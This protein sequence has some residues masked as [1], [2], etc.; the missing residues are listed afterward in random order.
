RADDGSAAW[1]GLNYLPKA[2]RFQLSPLG[3]GLYD[4]SCGIALFLA[5]LWS[6][7]KDH[8]F[9]D[10][11][12]EALLPL[13][14]DL[15]SLDPQNRQRFAKLIGADMELGS[16]LY[17]LVR[18]SQLLE[19]PTL[20]E[21]AKQAACL[22]T[23]EKSKNTQELDMISELAG[24]ILGLLAL[25][26]ASGDITYLEQAITYGYYILSYEIPSD[27][28]L[29]IWATTGKKPWISFAHGTDRIAYALLKLYE[30]TLDIN[31]L[32]GVKEMIAYERSH[33]F[34]GNG[35]AYLSSFPV[36]DTDEIRQ[37]I[38]KTLNTTQQ[39]SF[40]RVDRLSCGNFGIIDILLEASY[41]LSRPSLLA[42]A[43]QRAAWVV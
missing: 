38:E 22:M 34:S 6:V 19:E 3:Y 8:Q 27:V 25:Q 23:L 24:V 32:V 37:E 28:G 10:F 16:I 30:T 13:R 20:L 26:I 9:R 35:L 18:I 2:E 36:L 31:F 17:A 33:G 39:I 14:Q 11:A 7:T 29:K 43:Q 42:T 5:S 21:N 4:G 1:I 40:D 15:Q 41:K 12:L